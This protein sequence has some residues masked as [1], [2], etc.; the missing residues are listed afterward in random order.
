MNDLIEASGL[1]DSQGQFISPHQYHLAPCF[2]S[3]LRT[4][5]EHTNANRGDEWHSGQVDY[6]VLTG[7][8]CSVEFCFCCLRT[9]DV[10]TALENDAA[11]V[12]LGLVYGYFHCLLP[13]E[14]VVNQFRTSLW[15]PVAN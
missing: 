15:A 6:N 3:V 11:D 14:I 1:E 4:G 8:H 10:Q 2:G 13:V 5:H 9:S 12:C 7:R